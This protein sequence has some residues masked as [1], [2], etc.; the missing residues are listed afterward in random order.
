M[1]YYKNIVSQILKMTSDGFI[2]TDTEGNVREINKQYADFFGKSR[3]EIIGK[4]ILNIIPNSK[5]IDIV[6]HKFSEEDA[7][8]KYIDGEAKGNSVIVSRSYVEDEDGN[9]VAGV[10]QVKF[11]VQT[12]AVAKKLMNEY[13]ELEY[14]REEFQNQNRVDNIIGSDTKF[15]EIVKECLKVAKTDIP[16]LLTGETGTG[17]EVMAKALHT[18]S[19]R[20]DKP[21][22]SI[23]CAAIPFE[24]LESELFGYM[25]GA[26][27]GAKRGGKKGKFQLANGGTIFLDEIGDMPSSM[28]AKLLRVLQEKEIEP[29]GSEKSIPLD[30]RVVAATRQDLEAKMK[31]G[32]FREDLYYRLSVF[33]IHIP[34]LRER[35]G[36]SL[37]LAE[38]F[39]D[40]LNHKYKTYKTF[41]K[42]VKAYFLKY[43]WPGNV[44]E[45]NNVVQSA[46]AISTENII[47]INDI[48]ARMLQQE[49]PAINLDKNKKSLGQMVDDYEKEVILELLKKH[50][51]NCLE[52]AKEAGI[53]KSNFYRKLQKYGIKPAEVE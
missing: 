40:E 43:Q 44:R 35:G 36:D 18:N 52:A 13:E 15:R 20:C 28:Q 53:H 42:A 14:Y 39:L 29:L 9:V 8:H 26:F 19:L 46:Y 7:V 21:F 37:E 27:T 33:N 12:L 10:A 38:F 17:K 24:L 45:V 30:V 51:G 11:K 31:D 23:N 2:I 50:K 22:V 3:S 4:S 47:D 5:M 1:N 32:S 25:D 41:S 16:V 6:K 34:P 48:P 49:K